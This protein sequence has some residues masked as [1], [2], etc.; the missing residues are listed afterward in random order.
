MATSKKKTTR[1]R[2]VS[3]TRTKAKKK[4]PKKKTPKPVVVETPKPVVV[5]TPKPIVVETPKP[6]VVE[7]PK[8]VF[9]IL[10]R[11]TAWIEVSYE[12]RGIF[13]HREAG[14]F[15]PGTRTRL[16]SHLANQ[17]RGTEGIRLAG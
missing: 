1:R 16:R 15:V 11:E 2:S 4:A 12:G 8:P 3:K 6:I 5:E 13:V 14:V 17:L 9:K 7:T 10:P